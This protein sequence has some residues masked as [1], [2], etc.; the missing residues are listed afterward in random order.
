MAPDKTGCS[1]VMEARK[2]LSTET[3]D[4][5]PKKKFV[6]IA[7]WAFVLPTNPAACM[8]GGEGSN[9]SPPPEA[10]TCNPFAGHRPWG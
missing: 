4:N 8:L 5:R 10:A 9:V 7:S 3:H 2:H 6:S 1:G